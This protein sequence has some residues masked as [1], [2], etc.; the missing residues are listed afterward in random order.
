MQKQG[1]GLLA[2]LMGSGDRREVDC[3][4]SRDVPCNQE[5]GDRAEGDQDGT[6]FWEDLGKRVQ[7]SGSFEKR[8]GETLAVRRGCARN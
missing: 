6:L 7:E 3:N 8:S 4:A 5:R 2:G 1:V